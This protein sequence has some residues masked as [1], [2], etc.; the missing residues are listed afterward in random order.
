VKK[1][2]KDVFPSLS[3]GDQ[4]WNL[5]FATKQ[6]ASPLTTK[7]WFTFTSFF[8]ILFKG[9]NFKNLAFYFRTYFLIW[10]F[11]NLF[12]NFPWKEK[13]DWS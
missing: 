12:L 5:P 10:S 13:S 1:G 6:D 4:A 9:T 3:K 2:E 7:F 8:F 11:E